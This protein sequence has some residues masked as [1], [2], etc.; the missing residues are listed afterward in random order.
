[1]S[2]LNIGLQSVGVMRQKTLSFEEALKQ[3]NNLASIRSLGEENPTLEE[4]VLDAVAPMKA[5]LQGIFTRL[6]LS[7]HC[8]ETFEA[9]T[10]L[11]I[12]ELWRN[13]FGVEASITPDD[14]TITP[15]DTTKAKMRGKDDFKKFL[16][17][18]CKVRHYIMF[19][20]KKCNSAACV[21][22]PPRLPRC[23]TP[24]ST[25][26]TLFLMVTL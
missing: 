15:D 7:D 20:I 18:H 16:Q 12:D 14:T 6:R 9:A 1:M 10:K 24:S 19:S 23:S 11:A 8:F 13:I 21:C 22:K 17:H 26:Q 4:D 2:I 3:C 25:F 5:L